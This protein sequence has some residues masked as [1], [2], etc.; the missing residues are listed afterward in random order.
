VSKSGKEAPIGILNGGDF[1]GEGCL[2]GQVLR[3]CSAI[4]MTDCTVM[5]IEKKSMMDVIHREGAFSHVRGT[6]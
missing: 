5:R 4:T 2:T 6:C 3:S 1:F